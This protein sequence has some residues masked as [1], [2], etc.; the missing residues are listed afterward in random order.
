LSQVDFDIPDQLGV[1]VSLQP[2]ESVTVNL[3]VIHIFYSQLEDVETGYSLFTHLLP[4]HKLVCSP[5]DISSGLCDLP[6]D[7]INFAID[8][9]TD[10]HVGAEYLAT[11][12]K[13]V[14]A[15]R[16]GFYRQGTN[17]FFLK[18]T[19]NPQIQEFLDPIFGTSSAPGINHFTVGTG[20]TAGNFSLDFAADFN[21]KSEQNTETNGQLA[22]PG[23][24]LILSTVFRF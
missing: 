13:Y 21:Q 20:V 7:Q 3:D 1:G 9:K 17:R 22:D 5:S 14:W 2:T 23:Y 15:F 6:A 11:T 19:P 18:S 12:A 8:D 10:I 4:I 16:G 24:Q